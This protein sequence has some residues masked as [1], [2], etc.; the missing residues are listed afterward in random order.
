MFSKAI[1]S[2]GIVAILPTFNKKDSDEI[3][4]ARLVNLNTWGENNERKS[5]YLGETKIDILPTMNYTD[6]GEIYIRAKEEIQKIYDKPDFLQEHG[7]RTNKDGEEP[8][9]R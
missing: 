2:N 3:K 5:T 9:G 7:K 1:Q 8:G 4:R 6:F